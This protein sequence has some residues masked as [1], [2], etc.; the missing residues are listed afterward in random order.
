MKRLTSSDVLIHAETK[1]YVTAYPPGG[2]ALDL[3][4]SEGWCVST[5][6]RAENGNYHTY[7]QRVVST[8]QVVTAEEVS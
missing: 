7:L 4:G 5:I 2:D 8:N 1:I 3:Y 6:I